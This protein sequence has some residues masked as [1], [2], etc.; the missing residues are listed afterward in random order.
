MS[1]AQF[2]VSPVSLGVGPAIR[3]QRAG[4]IAKCTCYLACYCMDYEGLSGFS[5]PVVSALLESSQAHTHHIR[6]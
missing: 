3:Q 1:G 4:R 6:H 2:V 5:L